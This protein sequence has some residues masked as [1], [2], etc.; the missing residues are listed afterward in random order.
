[1]SW[2]DPFAG[3][4][5]DGADSLVDGLLDDVFERGIDLRALV[6]DIV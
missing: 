5:L 1:M 4:N 3:D 6:V 2:P